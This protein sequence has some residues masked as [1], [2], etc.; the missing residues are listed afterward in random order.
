MSARIVAWGTYGSVRGMGPLRASRKEAERDQDRDCDDC[1]AV[2]GGDCYS[3]RYVVAVDADG[4]CYREL[5][6]GGWGWVPTSGGA[7]GVRYEMPQ[8]SR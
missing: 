7:R 8:V 6:V 2:P 1:R 4:Y 5:A 3:D